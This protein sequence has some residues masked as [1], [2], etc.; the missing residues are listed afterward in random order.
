MLGIHAWL[1]VQ[2]LAPAQTSRAPGLGRLTERAGSTRAL[3]LAALGTAWMVGS[4]RLGG[5]G[6]LS[7][8]GPQKPS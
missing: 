4:P 8:F 5:K 2:G 7:S 6:W 3:A 1:G